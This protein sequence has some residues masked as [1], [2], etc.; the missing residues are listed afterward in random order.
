[1]TRV[2]WFAADGAAQPRWSNADSLKFSVARSV[3][4][5]LLANRNALA[6]VVV[7]HSDPSAPQTDDLL[8]EIHRSERRIPIIV[9]SAKF[10]AEDTI[11]LLRLGAHHLID[12][13]TT[14][15]RASDILRSAGVSARAN[16]I[17][18]DEPWRRTLVGRSEAIN[19]IIDVIRLVAARR[20]TVLISGETGTG[21]EVV[22]RAIHLAGGREHMPFVA[23]N[24]SAIPESLVESELFGYVRGAFTGAQQSRPGKF[25]Q[26]E[27]GTIFL[28]EISELPAEAQAKLLRVLQQREVQRLGGSETVKLNVRV[29][30][31]SNQD[32]GAAVRRRQFREDLF[33]RLNVVPLQLPPLRERSEDIPLLV[34]HF[35]DRICAAE[36]IERRRITHGAMADLTAAHWPGNIRQLE[37]AIEMAVVLSGGR[38]VLDARDFPIH[39]SDGSEALP[40][41][42]SA[43]P[44]VPDSGLDFEETVSRFERSL[45]Q[46]ALARCNG[47]KARAAQLLRM[48][49]TTLLAR[50]KSL[51][52]AGQVASLHGC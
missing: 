23:V 38:D 47:N 37:H 21:K 27:G 45:L 35:L 41:S 51:E 11:R 1:M 48:K 2:I 20:C 28:D 3:P 24:C 33:Y 30:A 15:E 22:A 49:R 40:A 7:L 34:E 14:T 32:L 18:S 39:D 8:L 25:E 9:M 17:A 44:L 6:D 43:H 46:Q 4:E 50:I 13:D 16:R 26:A 36:G 19:R 12:D 10:S 29:I 31:A 52:T 5:L 42:D